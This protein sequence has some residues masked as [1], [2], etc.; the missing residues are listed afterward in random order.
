V[1]QADDRMERVAHRRYW[2]IVDTG[3]GGAHADTASSAYAPSGCPS[4]SP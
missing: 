2:L 3:R 1:Q 4:A